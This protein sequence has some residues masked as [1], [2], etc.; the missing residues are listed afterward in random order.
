MDG[1][2]GA[3]CFAMSISVSMGVSGFER[4]LVPPFG[5]TDIVDRHVVMLAPE[6]RHRIENLALPQHIARGG[7]S[8]TLGH[9]PM[10]DPDVLPGVRV[11]PAGNIACRKNAGNAGFELR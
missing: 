9:H 11:G 7:L 3:T 4:Y 1:I 2:R 10:L 6:E 8:L 5:V